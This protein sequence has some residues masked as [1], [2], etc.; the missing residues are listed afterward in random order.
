MILKSEYPY[1]RSLS[2]CDSS[3]A[4]SS[5]NPA[6]TGPTATAGRYGAATTSTA[7]GKLTSAGRPTPMH[8]PNN[9]LQLPY[10]SVPKATIGR[11]GA[12]KPIPRGG[13]SRRSST[14]RSQRS[15]SPSGSGKALI[16]SCIHR[17]RSQSGESAASLRMTPERSN[18]GQALRRGRPSPRQV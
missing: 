15:S 13:S 5:P 16:G 14:A 12:R 17:A 7:P 6:A 9:D 11:W 18:A 2:C 1:S 4:P 3:A 10:R 8:C